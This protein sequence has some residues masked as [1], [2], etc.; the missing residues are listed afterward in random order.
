MFAQVHL[1]ADYWKGACGS[2]SVLCLGEDQA[3]LS[4]E[5]VLCSV[6]LCRASPVRPKPWQRRLSLLAFT[7]FD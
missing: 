5:A 4:A 7:S 3:R 2:E 1:Q 6:V